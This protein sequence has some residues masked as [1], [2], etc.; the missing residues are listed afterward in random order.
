MYINK[1]E[2][3][4]LKNKNFHIELLRDMII[5]IFIT[6]PIY[7]LGY[8]LKFTFA[9]V[10]LISGLLY[11]LGSALQFV[12]VPIA[13]VAGIYAIITEGSLILVVII[14]VATEILLTAAVYI[15]SRILDS[16]I[17][18]RDAEFYENN[19]KHC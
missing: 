12:A 11:W 18:K 3:C 14:F 6:F 10:L 2:V 5:H 4:K 16:N 7:V 13:I 1:R 15:S 19:M 8:V 9:I 17:K